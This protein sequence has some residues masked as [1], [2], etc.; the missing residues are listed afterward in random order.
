MK[1]TKKSFKSS[2]LDG[3]KGVVVLQKTNLSREKA[4]VSNVVA[5]RAEM[6]LQKEKTSD[7]TSISTLTP[8][9][10]VSNNNNIIIK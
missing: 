9:S 1:K 7:D 4:L 3:Y 2:I 5:A 8:H 10:A 6:R